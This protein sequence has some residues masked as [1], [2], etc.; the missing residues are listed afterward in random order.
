MEISKILPK[1]PQGF[2]DV[3]VLEKRLKKQKEEYWLKRGQSRALKLFKLMSARVPAYKDFLRKNKINPDKILNI[4]DFKFIPTIDKYNYLRQYPLESLCWDGIFNKKKWLISTT[5]GSTGEPFYFPRETEQDVQYAI[6]AELYLRTNFQIHKKSTLY[7]IGFPMGAWIGGVFTLEALRIVAERGGYNLSIISPGII[8]Q[9]II[10][11]IRNLGD[12]FDQ[13]IIGSYGPFLKDTLDD[14]IREGINWKSYNLG[15]IFSAEGFTEEFRD[16]V[17]KIAGTKNIYTATLNHYG[18]VDL[19]TM[20]YETPISIMARRY[21]IK[22]KNIYQQIFNDAIKLPTFTQYIPELHYFESFN[23]N[24]ICSAYSGLHL[25]R[26]DLKDHGGVIPFSDVYKIFLDSGTD[27]IKESIKEQIDNTVWNLPFVYVYER[28]DF[29][30]SFYAFQIYPET[31]RRALQKKYL[32]NKVTGKFT[33]L[34]KF[35]KEQNQYLEI[36]VEMKFGVRKSKN[37]EME[38]RKQI[39]KQL[40]EESSEYRE[41]FREISKRAEPKIILWQYEDSKYFKPGIKQKWVLK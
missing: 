7:I 12:K 20:S 10:K 3:I 35:S 2:N 26:Y 27:L 14:G 23:G 11:A 40:L 9:E 13:V 37:L 15:F 24:L 34:V 16:Y 32:E 33:M 31:V 28:S 21:S 41:T 17:M 8:K 25:V 6:L 38:I 22:N 29:S 5:S 1:I 39:T 18:T 30:V 36:N 19:G 4:S